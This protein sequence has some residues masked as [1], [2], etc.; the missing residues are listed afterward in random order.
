MP[1]LDQRHR[2]FPTVREVLHTAPHARAHTVA[3]RVL[4]SAAVP[5]A[6]V[7]LVGRLELT[8]FA[9]LTS[10][11][12]VYGRRA[13]RWPRLAVQAQAMALQIALLMIG[14]WVSTLSPHPWT[15]VLATAAVAGVCT[16]VADLRRWMPPGALFFVF[17]FAVAA[18]APEPHASLGAAA[19]AA[20]A[21][22]LFTLIV[23]AT[24]SRRAIKGPVPLSPPAPK[25]LVTVVH[26]AVCTIGAASAGIA[27]VA[28]GLTHP[29]WAMVSAVVPVVGL[30]TSGQTLRAIH[31]VVG[32]AAGLVLAVP[33]F[34][35]S[36]STPVLLA[37]LIGLMALTEIFIAR[38]YALALT[39]LTPFTVGLVYLTEAPALSE[40]LLARGAE[41]LL[42]A[43]IAIVLVLVTHRVRHP[44]SAVPR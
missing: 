34:S 5:V 31:R 44:Q 3:L 21:T 23:T 39:C 22:G 11:M 14:A 32:T 10:V 2:R 9:L 8:P 38:N 42:G 40:T 13:S 20:I 4:V 1:A 12:A 37:V 15:V 33:L 28:I 35:M 36:M 25:P 30:T 16:V 29:Y 6:V 7:Y 24:L 18:S 17:G 26:A 43:S 41:T 27:A 19:T